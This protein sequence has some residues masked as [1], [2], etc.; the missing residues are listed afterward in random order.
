MK[1]CYKS[2]TVDTIGNQ[3]SYTTGTNWTWKGKLKQVYE[4]ELNISKYLA[5]NIV[6][7]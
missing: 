2:F 5:G 4:A 3:S 1:F 6:C 7:F